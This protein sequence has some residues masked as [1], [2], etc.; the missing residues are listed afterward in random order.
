MA[1][2]YVPQFHLRKFQSMNSN[3]F[4]VYDREHQNIFKSSTK[5]VM[6][7]SDFNTIHSPDGTKNL[8]LEKEYSRIESQAEVAFR[9]AEN[10][11]TFTDEVKATLATYFATLWN[12]TPDAVGSNEMVLQSI[13][14]RAKRI[15]PTGKG[16]E[17]PPDYAKLLGLTL[18]EPIYKILMSFGWEIYS[19][20]NPKKSFVIGDSPIRW[21]CPGAPSTGFFGPS[22]LDSNS[23]FGVPISAS[24]LVVIRNEYRGRVMFGKY[25]DDQMRN[26][27]MNMA[28]GFKRF[29]VARDVELLKSLIKAI[30]NTDWRP[31]I[32]MS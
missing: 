1:D 11:E 23:C 21:V 2:H 15:D 6:A 17:I 9:K 20:Q 25:S 31:R 27:N 26:A 18:V 29:L 22:M 5:R 14:D 12:R 7:Q 3:Y 30:G 8:E 24:Q 16:L 28:R 4:W 32:R 10:P 19:P 13:A